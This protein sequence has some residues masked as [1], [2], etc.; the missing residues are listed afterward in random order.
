[1]PTATVRYGRPKGSGLDD[2]QQLETIAALLVADP[3]LKPTTAIRLLG[4]DD[5]STIRRLRD[6]FRHEQPQLMAKVQSV[7]SAAITRPVPANCN[8]S[9]PAPMTLSTPQVT[10]PRV[11]PVVQ[12]TSEVAPSTP[13][14]ALVGGWCDL[15][16]SLM[17]TAAEAQAVIVQH[18]LEQP[19]VASAMR[20]QLALNS[21]AVA[22]LNRSRGRRRT[23]H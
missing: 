4:V 8:K 19:A 5:P 16:I 22:G 6:K 15:T 10:P 2:R 11:A 17:R 12:R 21:V 18:W 9:T 3:K 14:A 23:F 13:A 1:M 20:R 7:G